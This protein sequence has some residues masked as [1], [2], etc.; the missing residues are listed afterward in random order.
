MVWPPAKIEW[1]DTETP[2]R[3]KETMLRTWQ[4]RDFIRLTSSGA[5]A[6]ALDRINLGLAAPKPLAKFKLGLGTYTFRSLDIV[7]LIERCHELGVRV[8]ELSH[9]QYMLPQAKIDAFSVVRDRLRNGQ[10]ELASWYCGHLSRRSEIEG[11]VEGVRLFGVKTVSGSADRDLLDDIDR[12]CEH[13]GFGF[14]I[15]NHYFRDRKFIYESP[16]DVLSALNGHPHLFATL[17]TG[18][19]IAIGV[20]PLEAYRK[21]RQRVRIIHLKDEDRPDHSV[22]LG[23]GNGQMA[24]FLLTIADDGFRGLGAIE[25][26]EGTDPKQ[27]VAECISFIRN[28]LSVESG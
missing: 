1:R 20:D 25:F 8:I 26:E 23:K 24:G 12:A 19:M 3:G 16:E 14:G 22:V 17:D 10:V 7:G 4:R 28:Q 21:L 6:V 9:P 11:L 27:E 18:H 2:L 5:G 15:H 13:A